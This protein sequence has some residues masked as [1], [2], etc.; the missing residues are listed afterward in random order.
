MSSQVASH[1]APK[2]T[3][4]QFATF[5]ADLVDQGV[6]C[7][8]EEAVARWDEFRPQ[9]EGIQRALDQI[10]AGQTIPFDEALAEMDAYYKR[11]KAARDAELAADVVEVTE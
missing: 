10:D 3:L 9:L 4:K 1:S 8:P 11:M 2:T 7:T 6:E 5:C